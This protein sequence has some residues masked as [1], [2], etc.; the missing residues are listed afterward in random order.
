M[1]VPAGMEAGMERETEAEG[2]RMRMCVCVRARQERENRE[3]VPQR[4]RDDAASHSQYSHSRHMPRVSPHTQSVFV[5]AHRRT[6]LRQPAQPAEAARQT[7]LA[8]LGASL[9][10]ALC[11]R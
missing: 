9:P 6:C 5:C 1:I 7:R 3:G 2:V 8:A 4:A 10:E 11:R